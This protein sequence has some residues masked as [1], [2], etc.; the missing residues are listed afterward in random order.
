MRPMAMRAFGF[1]STIL[2][3][4]ALLS[5]LWSY[6]KASTHTFSQPSASSTGSTTDLD[7]LTI[8]D[9]P[10]P[11][12]S[13]RQALTLE[14]IREHYSHNAVSISII[15][16]IIVI[17]WTGSRSPQSAWNA[18]QSD[19][20]PF[21]RPEIRKGG[22]VNVSAHFL[23]GRDGMVWRLMREDWM[24]RHTI[25]LNPI[26]IGIENV[27]GPSAP[28]TDKQLVSNEALVR[29]LIHKYPTIEYLI[30][31]YEYGHFRGTKY[32]AETDPTYFTYKIDPG[33]EFMRKLRAR[34]SDTSLGRWPAFPRANT[35]EVVH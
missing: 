26:A 18:F 9:W 3:V 1:G 2:V 15:P 20:L 5:G 7:R 11:F 35:S 22:R 16:R 10:I 31:H 34:L 6:T 12:G 13:R 30:G 19:T 28:L 14:Y 23:V 17:H 33:D 32:W 29:Y 4:A 27:G 21:W 8:V 25:G 24:A